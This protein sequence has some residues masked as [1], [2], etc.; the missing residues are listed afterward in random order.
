MSTNFV[1]HRNNLVLLIFCKTEIPHNSSSHVRLS[2]Q[3][4]T[5]LQGKAFEVSPLD[6]FHLQI[7]H[8]PQSFLSY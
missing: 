2:Q 6:P 7:I 1:A 3:L 8:N 5:F 4:A